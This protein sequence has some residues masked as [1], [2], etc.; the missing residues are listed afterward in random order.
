MEY[1]RKYRDFTAIQTAKIYME[2]LL[3]LLTLEFIG[4]PRKLKSFW[5]LQSQRLK[6]QESI[7]TTHDLSTTFVAKYN[8]YYL[9]NI[10]RT[11]KHITLFKLFTKI[12]LSQNDPYN[13]TIIHMHNNYL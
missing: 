1:C 5:T 3:I 2:L 8:L 10:N 11:L 9:C 6:D 12:C 7:S 4:L 13:V